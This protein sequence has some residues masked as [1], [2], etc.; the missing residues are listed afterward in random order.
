MGSFFTYQG[1]FGLLAISRA[2]ALPITEGFLAD[3]LTCRGWVR[4][5]C[6][7]SWL[8]ADSITLRA[9]SLLAVLHGAADLAFWLI[10]LDLALRAT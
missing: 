3:R 2:V 6:V 8:L 7:A 1:T 4:A 9:S 5:L 10:A